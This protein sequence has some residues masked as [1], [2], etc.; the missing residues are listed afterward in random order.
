MSPSTTITFGN[1]KT[2]PRR[3]STVIYIEG[4][5][6][7]V[8]GGRGNVFAKERESKLSSEELSAILAH[9]KRAPSTSRTCLL[10]NEIGA[11]YSGSLSTRVVPSCPFLL[12]CLPVRPFSILYFA[13]IPNNLLLS[14]RFP[15]NCSVTSVKSSI[16]SSIS[17]SSSSQAPF[18]RQ[19]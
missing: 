9:I 18:I 15:L 14:K 8:F 10:L 13:S 16:T 17:S 4:Q 3:R 12:R 1:R 7:P 2:P 19:L 11:L 6:E 5:Q